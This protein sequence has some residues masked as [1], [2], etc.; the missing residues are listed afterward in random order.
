MNGFRCNYSF[1]HP[2]NDSV[3]HLHSPCL[4][5]ENDSP[6]RNIIQISMKE[7]PHRVVTAVTMRYGSLVDGVTFHLSDGLLCHVGGT[8]G[9]LTQTV[10]V[11]S[12]CML[13]GLFGGL[14]VFNICLAS[15]SILFLFCLFVWFLC[16]IQVL[17]AICITWDWWCNQ[18]HQFIN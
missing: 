17:G 15:F 12:D 16:V 2:L 8:G 13:V 9:H 3:V 5:G 7:N 4:F 1:K 11:P 18:S 6:Q 14:I 10:N